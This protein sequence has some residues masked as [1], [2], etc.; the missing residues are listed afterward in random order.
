MAGWQFWID[1][2]GTFTDI[3]ARHPD[4]RLSAHKLLSD[5]P[6]RYD[7]AAVEGMRRILALDPGAEFPADRVEAIKMGTTVATN[8]LLERRG[9]PTLLLITRGFRDALLI[10]QQNRPKLFALRIERPPPLYARVAEVD[11]RLAADGTVL[12]PLDEASLRDTLK[13]ARDAGLGAVAIAFLHGY[14]YPAHEKRAAALAREAGF[15]QVSMSHEVSPLVK[16][17]PRGQTTVADAYLSPVLRR[18]VE[19]VSEAVGGAPLYFMQSSGGLAAASHFRGKDAILSGPAGGVVGAVE[20]A[21]A[22]GFERIIGFDM[23]GTSTDV[24]HFAGDYERSLDAEV[25]G[26]RLQVPMMAVHT[27]AAGGGSVCRFDGLRFRVGPESAGADPGPVSYR[28]GGPL[29]ITDCNLMLGKLQPD[30]FPAVFGPTGDQ[31]LDL[32]AV[33]AAFAILADEIADATGERKSP[34]AI[35]EGFVTVAVEH[36]ARAIKAITVERGHDVTRYALVVFGGAGGQHGC[37]VAD[38]LGIETVLVHPMAGVLSALGIG[39]AD[40]RRIEKRTLDVPL[41]AAHEAAIGHALDDL[42]TAARSALAAQGV[43]AADIRTLRQVHARYAGTDTSL[44]VPFASVAGARKAFEDA[45]RRLFGFVDPARRVLVEAASVEAIGAGARAVLEDRAAGGTHEPL[46][47]RPF[48]SGGRTWQAP[49]YARG[50]LALE[51]PVEGPAIILEGTATTI[52]E[53]GWRAVRTPRGDLVLNRVARRKRRIAGGERPDPVLLEVFNN[54]FMSVAEQM[55][56]VL[57]RTAHSVNMKER[58]DFSCAVFDADGNLVANAPH[59]P[60]HLGSMGE[61]VKAVIAAMAGDLC[62]GDAVMMNDPYGGGTHLPDV[63]VVTPVFLE[64]G[65][66]GTRPDFFVAARGH[67]AD[68]GGIAPGSMPSHSTR[69]EE[70]GILIPPTRIVRDGVFAEEAVRRLLTAAPWPARNPQQNIADLR[71]QLAATARGV[72]ELTRLVESFGH[73]TVAAYMAHVRA[74]A[75]ESVRRVI[76]RLVDGEAVYPMDCGATIRVAIRV[77]QRRRTACVDFTGTSAQHAGNFNAPRAI[78]RAAVLY[79][80]RCLVGEDIPLNDGCLAPITIRLPRGSILDPEPPAAVVAGNVETSQA[81]TNALFLAT[82]ALAAAQG[83]MNN[84]TFGNAAHQYYET[85][86]GGAGAGP[87][88]DG[89][90]AVHTHMTNSRLTDAEVLESRHPVRIER[91]AIRAGSGGAGRWHGG[92]GVVREIAF[93]EAMDV[94]ILSGHREIPPPG[95]AGGAPGACGRNRVHRADGRI[96]ALAGADRTTVAP[97]D[98]LVIE[99]PGGGGYGRPE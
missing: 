95:L 51:R 67:H 56:V 99:T 98:R 16:L 13:A 53:P 12:R 75:E 43:A 80:F 17:V 39:L 65:G 32:A 63:T 7:D 68:I 44:L 3:V 96:E 93:L 40:M 6:G 79:V 74:N 81:V 19:R 21:R 97:G 88:F 84:L 48:H 72:A 59:M 9:T 58:L 86:C 36:M 77:D 85:L 66:H 30:F 10:A 83:T 91:F 52:V 38:A 50:D 71:A 46:A 26:V 78:T 5:A 41:D 20:T 14:R 82:G 18:Y 64:S 22:A 35:A 2:G 70:E 60:V 55:G 49:V 61:S 73:A 90:S 25:A 23:G 15:A 24:S 31:P 57:E 8:A 1:R 76:D 92:D 62:P 87:G 29:A 69:I 42:E 34:Q 4:G 89:A 45:H 28:N 27:V 47:V 11:E 37:L 94:N 54:L 33:R